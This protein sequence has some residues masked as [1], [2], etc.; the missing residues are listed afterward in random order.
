MSAARIPIHKALEEAFPQTIERWLKVP[1]DEYAKP[2]HLPT[3]EIAERVIRRADAVLKVLKLDEPQVIPSS[4]WRNQW[5]PDK[6][7]GLLRDRLKQFGWTVTFI[8]SPRQL[9]SLSF[10]NAGGGDTI[11]LEQPAAEAFALSIREAGF[12][13]PFEAQDAMPV[14]LAFELYDVAAPQLGHPPKEP[15][16]DDLARNLVAQRLLGLPFNPLAVSII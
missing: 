11:F 16:V 4:L 13:A 14:L 3:R 12:P 8:E 6:P 5:R 1:G 7:F 2:D 9:S 10:L 15:W